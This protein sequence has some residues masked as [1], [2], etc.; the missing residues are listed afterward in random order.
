MRSL[1]RYYSTPTRIY[2]FT[3]KKNIRLIKTENLTKRNGSYSHMYNALKYKK[4]IPVQT[5]EN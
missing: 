1:I 4:K 2:N 5:L 3:K